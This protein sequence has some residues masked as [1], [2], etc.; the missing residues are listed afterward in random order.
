MDSPKSIFFFLRRGSFI[1][2]C[3]FT[4]FF[5]CVFF[6]CFF[7]LFFFCIFWYI[8]KQS[9]LPGIHLNDEPDRGRLIRIVIVCQSVNR[10]FF[11]PPLPTQDR[12]F[13]PCEKLLSHMTTLVL[14]TIHLKV[15]EKETTM[16]QAM[17]DREIPPSG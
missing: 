11:L 3:L 6:F 16:S 1:L 12:L 17:Q 13:C 14:G 9:F 15:A 8:Q 4:C 7:C 5:F 10:Y 2:L